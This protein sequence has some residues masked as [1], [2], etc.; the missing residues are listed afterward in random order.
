MLMARSREPGAA[1]P[2]DPQKQVRSG[3]SVRSCAA[4]PA[5]GRAAVDSLPDFR[6][7]YGR[8]WVTG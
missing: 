3:S 7:S 1:L 4:A 6:Q 8:E 2:C 5:H